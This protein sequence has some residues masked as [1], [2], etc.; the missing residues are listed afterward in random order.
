LTNYLREFR[1]YWPNITGATLGMSVS[2]ALNQYLNSLFA[3]PL[4]AEF[5]W[6][7][8][9]LALTTSLMLIALI[10]VPIAGRF[11]DR[12]GARIAGTVGF[13]MLPLCYLA[14]SMMTGNIMEFYAI[15]LAMGI[16]G[17][18]TSSLVFSRAIVERF[19]VARGLALSIFTSGPPLVSAI[20][21]PLMGEVVAESWR[22]GYQVLA[23][24]TAVCGFIAV[25]LIG[26]RKPPPQPG[27]VVAPARQPLGRAELLSVVRNPVFL[28][29]I[30]GMLLIN[31]PQ[32]IIY[33]QLVLMLQENGASIELATW[34]VSLYALSVVVGRFACGY[35]LDHIPSH[36]VAVVTLGLPAI[37]LFALA[38]PFD[39]SWVL[40]GAIALAGL[41][42]GAEND[43][44]GVMIAQKF[45]IRH[46]SLIYGLVITA[47]GVSTA[48]GSLVLS[49][50][51]ARSDSYDDFLF[52]SGALTMA[53]VVCFYLTGRHGGPQQPI[54]AAPAPA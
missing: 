13:T 6:Q 18:L 7:K 30:G 21:V 9:Q 20:A 37:G 8:S 29:M 10:T 39:A 45:A 36:V 22:T 23:G 26:L 1:V 33:T 38:S 32:V 43:V 31:F 53:G 25:Y 46:Y 17:G 2:S 11:V 19:D 24:L 27:E 16:F 35:A 44:G 3:P 28:L 48:V 49:F 4:I 5:G 51:L 50:M 12:V 41:A 15:S 54:E 34:L 42:Q 14:F 40:I 52:L 47:M